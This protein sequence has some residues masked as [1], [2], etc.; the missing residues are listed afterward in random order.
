[1][2]N[3]LVSL[4]KPELSSK[5]TEDRRPSPEI[6]L[7]IGVVLLLRRLCAFQPDAFDAA[8]RMLVNQYTTVDSARPTPLCSNAPRRA[9]EG[10]HECPQDLGPPSKGVGIQNPFLRLPQVLAIIPVSRSTWW[11]GVRR[12]IYPKPTRLS[13]RTIAWRRTDINA[14]CAR[15][16][17]LEGNANP[18]PADGLESS[19]RPGGDCR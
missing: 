19:V 6:P 15:L 10:G 16:A 1:M 11:A 18:D 2:G 13:A 14:L 5:E 9:A 4:R 17:D 8:A 7:L 3:R 12:G